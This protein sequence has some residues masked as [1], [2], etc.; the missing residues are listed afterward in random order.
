MIIE[1]TACVGLLAVGILPLVAGCGLAGRNGSNEPI[2]WIQRWRNET[3]ETVAIA[4]IVKRS[5][6]PIE[7]D[8]GGIKGN[9]TGVISGLTTF[10]ESYL[11]RWTVNDRDLYVVDDI[12]LRTLVP[13]N[14][15]DV[16]GRGRGG[17]LMTELAVLPG[18]RLRLSWTLCP[19]LDCLDV[20]RAGYRYQASREFQGR[21]EATARYPVPD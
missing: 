18:G 2:E 13:A 17:S 1:V 12:P 8:R 20:Y 19:R 21:L 3:G 9:T 11:V 6:L 14:T 7:I 5:P 16:A 4:H 15:L 10:G